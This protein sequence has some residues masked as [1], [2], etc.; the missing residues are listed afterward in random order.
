[1]AFLR[2]NY[3]VIPARIL[4][5]NIMF[6]SCLKVKFHILHSP[7]SGRVS[8][9]WYITAGYIEE[10]KCLS[11]DECVPGAAILISLQ[12]LLSLAHE[13]IKMNVLLHH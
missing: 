10:D 7:A 12:V 11:A 5:F 1:M 13:V 3:F 9:L 2:R 6:I 4:L 8:C